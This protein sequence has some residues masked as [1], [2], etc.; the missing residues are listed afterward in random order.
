MAE[1]K[2]TAHG[3][4]KAPGWRIPDQIR[5][6]FAQ[7]CEKNN[8]S[9]EEEATFAVFLWPKLPGRIQEWARRSMA[10]DPEYGPAF[11]KVFVDSFDEAAHEL[12]KL[13]RQQ[14]SAKS[15]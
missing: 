6:E 5:L 9:L 11:W 10:N 13:L 2:Y 12:Q 3:E 8:H 1:I 15:G 4:A 14:E 7:W